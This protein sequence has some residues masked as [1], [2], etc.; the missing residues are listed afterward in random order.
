MD[1]P[2]TYNITLSDGRLVLANHD[3]AA[4][5][6]R[7]WL[8]LPLPQTVAQVNA[9]ILRVFDEIIP[10]MKRNPEGVA[11]LSLESVSVIYAMD[12]ADVGPLAAEFQARL[13]AP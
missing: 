1:A 8:P 13:H 7:V 3:R 4:A 5:S 11:G 6:L 12:A 2:D 10:P 9:I